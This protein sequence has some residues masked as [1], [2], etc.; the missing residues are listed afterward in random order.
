[1]ADIVAPGGEKIRT[2]DNRFFHCLGNAVEHA[3]ENP[4]MERVEDVPV[5]KPPKAPSGHIVTAAEVQ[6]GR[7]FMGWSLNSSEASP[8]NLISARRCR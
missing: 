6:S 8:G 3:E 7:P 4:L 2:L 1:V 5:K